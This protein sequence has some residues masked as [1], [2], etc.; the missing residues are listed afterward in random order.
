MKR[1]SI[2][3]MGTRAG[4]PHYGLTCLMCPAMF[5]RENILIVA[6][7]SREGAARRWAEHVAAGHEVAETRRLTGGY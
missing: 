6:H 1:F 5:G 4:Q 3:K 2:R 7:A